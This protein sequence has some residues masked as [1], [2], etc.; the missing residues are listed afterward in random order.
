MLDGTADRGRAAVVN[1]L[2]NSLIKIVELERRL[3]EQND[4]E[5]RLDELEG[6]LEEAERRTFAGR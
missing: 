6:L 4:L 3:R 1:Q 5:A 2:Y